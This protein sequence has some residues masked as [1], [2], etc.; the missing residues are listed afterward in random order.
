MLTLTEAE[1]AAYPNPSQENLAVYAKLLE[2]H[3]ANLGDV[4][5]KLDEAL[6]EIERLP[7]LDEMAELQNRIE[8]LERE[9][10]EARGVG[11]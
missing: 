9:L 6:E 2:E 5:K 10:D 7:S 3:I 1:T 11:E 8:D 4:Q